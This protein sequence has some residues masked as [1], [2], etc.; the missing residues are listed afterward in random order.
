M[1]SGMRTSTVTLGIAG[2]MSCSLALVWLLKPYWSFFETKRERD[3][4][5]ELLDKFQLGIAAERIEAS[6]NRR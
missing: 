3:R 5:Q 6:A 2:M 4:A 1:C